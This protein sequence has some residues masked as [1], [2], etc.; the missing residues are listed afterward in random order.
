METNETKK[1]VYI[2][3][4]GNKAEVE[5]ETRNPTTLGARHSMD[6]IKRAAELHLPLG[7]TYVGSAVVHYYE[8]E[9]LTGQ[10]QYFVACHCDVK[11]VVEQHAD[12]GWKQLKSSLM[13]AYG[14]NDPK[15]RN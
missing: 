15:T 13:R 2:G 4:T 3:D 8:K 6:L 9:T 7:A 14:R 11:K 12:L 5:E 1:D 10:P